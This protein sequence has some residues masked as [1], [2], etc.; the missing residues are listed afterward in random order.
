[1]APRLRSGQCVGSRWADDQAWTAPRGRGAVAARMAAR[2]DSVDVDGGGDVAEVRR[3]W[4]RGSPAPVGRRSARPHAPSRRSL[5]TPGRS[6]G[7]SARPR[8]SGLGQD[9]VGCGK[10]RKGARRPVRRG[11]SGAMRWSSA[12]LPP[13]GVRQRVG[14]AEPSARRIA[15]ANSMTR[16]RLGLGEGRAIGHV[17]DRSAAAGLPVRP[18]TNAPTTASGGSRSR[19]SRQLDSDE[20]VRIPP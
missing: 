2:A 10:P 3:V 5:A 12:R 18:L 4:R 14:H 9:G 11:P 8:K 7:T 17:G 19:S 16:S 1:M 20:H 13:A 6:T 15:R